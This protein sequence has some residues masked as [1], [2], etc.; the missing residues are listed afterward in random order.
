MPLHVQNELTLKNPDNSI[1]HTVEVSGG[2]R[3]FTDHFGIYV[4]Q[5][6]DPVDTPERLQAARVTG[7][8]ETQTNIRSTRSLLRAIEAHGE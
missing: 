3:Y 2:T 5:T 8:F 4:Y 6:K 1:T 7:H